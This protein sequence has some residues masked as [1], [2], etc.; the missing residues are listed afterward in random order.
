MREGCSG[1]TRRSPTTSRSPQ[2]SARPGGDGFSP[3]T[4]LHLP[5]GRGGKGRRGGRGGSRSLPLVPLL[6]MDA[7]VIINDESQQSKKFEFIVPRTQFIDDVWTFSLCNRDRYVVLWCILLRSFRSCSSSLS[8]DIPFR[9]AETDSHGPHFVADHR[10][11]PVVARLSVVDAP[12]VLSCLPAA[13]V[14]TTGAQS[15]LCWLRCTSRCFLFPGSQAHDARHHGLYE[16]KG[17][18][19]WYVQCWYSWC[20]CTSRCVHLVRKP[21]MIGIT[22][23]M[24]Q[25]NT[26]A[27]LWSRQCKLSGSAAVPQLQFFASRHHPCR[28]ALASHGPD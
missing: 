8:V 10:D 19:Q 2:R 11:F 20:Q 6:V 16:P 17:Q 27:R 24:D 7:P 9:A 22:E 23:V 4:P 3:M 1:S 26:F 5:L 28:G 25:K 13:L 14:S 15:W 21:M 18:L 12:V